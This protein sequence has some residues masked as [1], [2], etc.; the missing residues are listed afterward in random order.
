MKKKIILDCDPGHD[1]AV[2]IMLAGINEDIELL[3]ICVSA[4]N[5]TIEKTSLNALNVTQYLGIDVPIAIGSPFPLVK[6]PMI[7]EEIHGK[8]GLDGFI[9][10][11]YPRNFLK[12]HSVDFLINTLNKNDKVTLVVTGPMTN[13]AMA[14]RKEPSIKDNI[15]QIVIMGGSTTSG[16]I[17]QEAEFNIYVDPEAAFIVFNSGIPLRMIG[18]NVTRRLLVKDEILNRFIP[19]NNKASKLFVD[20]MKVFNE[21]QRKFFGLEAGPLHDPATIVSLIDPTVFTF[22]NMDVEIDISH[23]ETYGKTIC[24]YSKNKNCEVAVDVD[25]NKFWNVIYQ[26]IIKC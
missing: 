21:N 16:N 10:P 23:S 18:L 7:C 11:D 24:K 25:I 4:G 26:H 2:A 14:L 17:T 6:E 20:L 5:Q 12:E 1:D 3:G 13:V 19:I 22:D 15:E 9:F 8:S